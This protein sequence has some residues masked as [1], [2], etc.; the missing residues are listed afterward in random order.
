MS[1]SAPGCP[2]PV[3]AKGLCEPHYRRERRAAKGTKVR[4]GPVRAKGSRLVRVHT[5]VEPDVARKLG[6]DSAARAR[7]ILTEWARR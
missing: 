1:C 7:E 6:E 4:T 3:F 2:R 5:S